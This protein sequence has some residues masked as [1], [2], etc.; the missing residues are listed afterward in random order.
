MLGASKAI[1]STVAIQAYTVFIT[2]GSLSVRFPPG[3]GT[4]SPAISNVT[5]G[6]GPFTYLWVRVSGS[7]QITVNSPT[8]SQTGFSASGSGGDIFNAVFRVTVTDTGNGNLETS[9]TI[10]VEIEFEE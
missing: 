5:G 7:G 4:T 6:V 2:P 9:N 1:A 8:N 10:S 3:S